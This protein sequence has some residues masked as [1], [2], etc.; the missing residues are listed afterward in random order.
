MVLPKG[1]TVSE[2]TISVD[3]SLSKR[4]LQK[5]TSK[6]QADTGWYE[7]ILAQEYMKPFC[8][9]FL[10]P[11]K[12]ALSYGTEYLICGK[13]SDRENL[14]G[15]VNRLLLLRETVN[16]LNLH[17][18][19]TKKAEAL[20]TATALAGASANPA[21]VELVKQGILAAWAYAE[22]ICD[23]KALLSGGKV[24]LQK[25]NSNWQMKLSNLKGAA[26]SQYSGESSGLS[27]ENY[28]D[29]FLY[30]QSQQEIAYRCMDLMEHHMQQEEA[31][32]NYKMD[33]M[34][35]AMELEVAYEA[36]TMFFDIFGEDT[37]G[38]Y[39][40]VKQADYQYQ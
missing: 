25:N 13:G 17:T 15:T 31:Y 10:S 4:T 1:K 14:E 6:K 8:G 36:S 32:Q 20:A 9:N 16:Y 24:P 22:S 38:S 30:G 27:Y 40:F 5:G 29:A 28:L 3:N 12:G 35:V 39:E 2:N 23:V 19:Q 26:S 18:D 33:S 7:R 21:V 37:I 34:I 11:K